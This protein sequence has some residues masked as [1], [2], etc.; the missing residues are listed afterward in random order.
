MRY[1]I[2]VLL[3]KLILV[4]NHIAFYWRY[5]MKDCLEF[6]VIINQKTSKGSSELKTKNMNDQKN[7]SPCE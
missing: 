6:Y 5:A 2:E 3:K 1:N 4:L 7:D